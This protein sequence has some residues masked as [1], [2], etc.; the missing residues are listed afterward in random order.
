MIEVKYE[1][2]QGFAFKTVH[3]G[4][5]IGHMH[6]HTHKMSKSHHTK[7]T[8]LLLYCFS[9]GSIFFSLELNELSGK[10]GPSET[11]CYCSE[12]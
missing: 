9:Y 11:I 12:N 1:G 4:K 7:Q 3:S 6:T 5:K 8:H 2:G 10:S